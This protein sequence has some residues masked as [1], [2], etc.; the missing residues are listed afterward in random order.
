MENNSIKES[1]GFSLDFKEKI[2]DEIIILFK[3]IIYKI[4]KLK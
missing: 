1:G 4:F 3:N 2:S